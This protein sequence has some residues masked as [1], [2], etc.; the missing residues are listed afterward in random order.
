MLELG[1]FIFLG[2]CLVN[3][4]YLYKALNRTKQSQENF[5]DKHSELLESL[6]DDVSECK[7]RLETLEQKSI[8]EQ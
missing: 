1:Y 2:L 8:K 3:S 4:I 6:I 5:M 7:K